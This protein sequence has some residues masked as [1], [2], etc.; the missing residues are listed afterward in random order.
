MSL[1]SK[2]S[3]GSG[4]KGIARTEGS[5]RDTGSV[6]SNSDLDKIDRLSTTDNAKVI[7]VVLYF[8]LILRFLDPCLKSLEGKRL[9]LRLN[10]LAL[11]FIFLLMKL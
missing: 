7:K 6:T 11:K 2:D 5:R 3:F 8:F 4:K 9:I 10:Y 1:C